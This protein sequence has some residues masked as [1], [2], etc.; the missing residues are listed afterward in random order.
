MACVCVHCERKWMDVD[1]NLSP[2]C[3]HLG[4]YKIPDVS[5]IPS[6]FYCWSDVNGNGVLAKIIVRDM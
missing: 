5:L 3:G 2:L 4:Q 1:S 6:H